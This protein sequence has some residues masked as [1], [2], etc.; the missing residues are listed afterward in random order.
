MSEIGNAVKENA[1]ASQD[2][3]DKIYETQVRQ[4]YE[5]NLK[6]GN[7][8][9]E[10]TSENCRLPHVQRALES[11]LTAI[12]QLTLSHY[13]CL[14]LEGQP[15]NNGLT[16]GFA[17]ITSDIGKEIQKQLNDIE[18]RVSDISNLAQWVIAFAKTIELHGTQKER[19]FQLA[20][21]TIHFL[22]ENY[23]RGVMKASENHLFRNNVYAV[24]VSQDKTNVYEAKVNTFDIVIPFEDDIHD[25][26][27]NI[28][29]YR[30]NVSFMMNDPSH[31]HFV[32]DSLSGLTCDHKLLDHITN[33]CT[34]HEICAF[35]PYDENTVTLAQGN[36]KQSS[37]TFCKKAMVLLTGL[38]LNS[39][40]VLT[41]SNNVTDDKLPKFMKLLLDERQTIETK[42]HETM[43]EPEYDVTA[44]PLNHTKTANLTAE[45]QPQR[46]EA[47]VSKNFDLWKE[48]T[49]FT[50]FMFCAFL[51]VLHWHHHKSM[52][53]FIKD[54]QLQCVMIE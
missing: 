49:I 47:V 43:Q 1:K 17:H 26:V 35:F 9:Y 50:V 16:V 15:K 13:V 38:P 52:R 30:S 8:F 41:N 4:H 19:N 53:N 6:T 18:N 34:G 33:Q 28:F 44:E 54:A 40:P 29:V 24:K 36:I 48:V 51:F 23:G 42:L 21:A 31:D 39:V 22:T 2:M 37:F 3:L 20:N 14:R 7:F 45:S 46:P 11:I 25:H 27:Y 32:N 12:N 10:L 5:K